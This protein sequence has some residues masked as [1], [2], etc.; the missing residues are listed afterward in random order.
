[1]KK[2]LGTFIFLIS[3]S[4][5]AL[6]CSSMTAGSLKTIEINTL[7][8]GASLFTV[9]QDETISY[10]IGTKSQSSFS[11]NEKYLVYSQL[12]IEHSLSITQP[13]Q[14]CRARIC[15]ANPFSPKV[16]ILSAD[17]IDNEY[18]DCL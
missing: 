12:G 10:M 4:N 9:S 15:N 18:F 5:Q 8:D 11:F 14:H 3:V 1:M 17:G 6:T 16:G 13:I 2:I 7:K